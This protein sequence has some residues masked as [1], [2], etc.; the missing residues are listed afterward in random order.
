VKF[1]RLI[2]TGALVFGLFWLVYSYF[3]PNDQTRILKLY[4]QLA[5]AATMPVKKTPVNTVMA[6]DRIQSSFEPN[7]E[8]HIESPIE[9][10]SA[11]ISGRD[12]LMQAVQAAWGHYNNI[13]VEISNITVAVDASGQTA[14]STLNVKAQIPGERDA[15]LQQFR[16]QLK[17]SDN[18]WRIARMD[19]VKVFH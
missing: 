16:V 1:L 11:G 7:V 17:K 3:F 6:M 4:R 8:I 19:P 14:S 15:F 13:K 10:L 18:G 5:A 9:G 2:I 12:D